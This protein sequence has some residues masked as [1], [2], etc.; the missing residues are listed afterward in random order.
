METVVT[1]K[2]QTI[3][4]LEKLLA[5]DPEI[6]SG[7]A[8]SGDVKEAA[9]ALARHAAA[10]GVSL[11]AAEIETAFLART[12][13]A[14]AVEPLDD[15]ALDNVAGGGSPYCIFTKGCYCIFTK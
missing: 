6:L 11:T 7:V 2:V 12:D 1:G 13:A 4:T 8:G 14:Q 9:A 15:A 10:K 5:D 3:A